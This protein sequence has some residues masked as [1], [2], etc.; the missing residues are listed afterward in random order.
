M[1]FLGLAGRLRM[2]EF[3]IHDLYQMRVFRAPSGRGSVWYNFWVS[4][5]VQSILCVCIISS[6]V[7]GSCICVYHVSWWWKNVCANGTGQQGRLIHQPQMSND[8]V[9]EE[10]KAWVTSWCCRCENLDMLCHWIAP[11]VLCNRW[12]LWHQLTSKRIHF[13]AVIELNSAGCVVPGLCWIVLE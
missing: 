6:R 8:V 12:S 4:E 7:R 1:Q 3:S 10:M 5:W 11:V 9:S 2:S 13:R